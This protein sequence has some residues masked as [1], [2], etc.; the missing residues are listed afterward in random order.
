MNAPNCHI[1]RI[2]CFFIVPNIIRFPK[3]FPKRL[4]VYPK[5]FAQSSILI[6]KLD[7]TRSCLWNCS[8]TG[9]PKRHF[10]W[11]V[12]NIPKKLMM[13]QLI[14]LLPKKNS[15]EHTHESHWLIYLLLIFTSVWKEDKLSYPKVGFVIK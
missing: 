5:R 6:E 9:S 11:G 8:V 10:Y 13:G 12:P 3:M 2:F 14:F 15:C 4:T 7:C 1:L